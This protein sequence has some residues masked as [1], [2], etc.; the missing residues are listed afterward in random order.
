MGIKEIKQIN[1]HHKNLEIDIT[2]DKQSF[3]LTIEDYHNIMY[4]RADESGYV[5]L[6]T[7]REDEWKQRMCKTTE[8]YEYIEFDTNCYLS[9]NT[10][11]IPKR[12]I[13]AVR[14]LNAFYVD[15][16]I[17]NMGVSKEDVLQAIEFFV[18]TE[19]ILRPTFVVSSGRGLYIIWKIEDVPGYYKKT[20]NMYNHVQ[21]Y[22]VDTFKDLGA[23][24][25]AKDIARVLR[26][27]GTTNTKNNQRVEIIQYNENSLYTMSMFREFIDE[28]EEFT[29][30]KTT[31]AKTKSKKSA[32]IAYMFNEYTLN[33]TRSMD[34]EK[35]CSLRDYEMNGQRDTILYIY[36]Y[37]MLL[38]HKDEQVA[39][40][41]TLNLNDRFTESLTEKQV[42]TYVK[43]SIRAYKEHLEDKKKGYNF[44]HETLVK[45]L[46]IT[47][48]EQKE[49][50]AIIG[51]REK[52]D[53]KNEKRNPRN[54]EGLTSRQAAKEE[55]IKKVKELYEQG[56]KQKDIAE[57][58]E[59]TK[60]RVSQIVKELKKV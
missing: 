5:G 27:P 17:Y 25:A 37:Y 23:D 39:L 33:K 54:E 8:W 50:D 10:F 55:L 14:H 51:T 58:L 1:K 7:K 45:L 24:A 49:M 56:Y 2:T 6:S 29:P 30:Q 43:S 15:L 36:H 41:N 38:I 31:T 57:K 40:Y 59:L 53:R 28:F 13:K 47:P 60:G 34:I 11:F 9:I 35:L 18:H 20:K 46:S 16:D 4:P 32:K 42:K 3:T 26:V 52:Y 44:K 48:E 12:Q 19:R 21:E 22:L